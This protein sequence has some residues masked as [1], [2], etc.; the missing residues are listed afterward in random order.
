MLK[1]NNKIT[2]EELKAYLYSLENEKT[3]EIAKQINGYKEKCEEIQKD[4]KAKDP[5]V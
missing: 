1:Q 3:E 2:I 4:V 5:I